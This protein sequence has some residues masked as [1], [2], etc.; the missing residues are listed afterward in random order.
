MTQRKSLPR[1]LPRITDRLRARREGDAHSIG[2]FDR[3]GLAEQEAL[4]WPT[5]IQLWEP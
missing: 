3:D 2:I 4:S 5:L 1:R